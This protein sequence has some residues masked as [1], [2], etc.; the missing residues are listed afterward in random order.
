MIV[1]I[2]DQRLVYIN[3]GTAFRPLQPGEQV[4]LP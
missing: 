3:T 4:N 2:Q 1:M